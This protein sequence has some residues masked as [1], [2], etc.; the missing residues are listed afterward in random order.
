MIKSRVY[1]WYR[2]FKEVCEN[3]DGKHSGCPST[4]T[5]WRSEVNNHERLPHHNQKNQICGETIHGFCTMIMHLPTLH[6]LYMAF[7]FIKNNL[8]M[9]SQ[10][11]CFLD[12]PLCFT[13][14]NIKHI[15][16]RAKS[17]SS[18]SVLGV[19]KNAVISV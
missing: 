10:L 9:M 11:P 7:F 14:I 13:S 19:G 2:S 5:V 15:A 16:E 6:C 3:E 18:K 17:Y 12:E 8:V 1:E 4:S